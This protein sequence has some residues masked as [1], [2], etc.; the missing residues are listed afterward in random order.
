MIVHM[1]VAVPAQVVV[2]E[3]VA[4]AV[5]HRV[6]SAAIVNLLQIHVVV[7]LALVIVVVQVVA[8]VIVQ[9]V[10]VQVATVA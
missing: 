7:V 1:L 6:L 3:N 10:V 2:P 9:E 8:K 4:K 5:R